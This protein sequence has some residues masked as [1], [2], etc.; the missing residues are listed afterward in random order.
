MLMV[1]IEV[2][3]AQE[4]TVQV[5]LAVTLVELVVPVER[6]EQVETYI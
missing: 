3:V 2:M 6:V 5:E 4:E 1:D